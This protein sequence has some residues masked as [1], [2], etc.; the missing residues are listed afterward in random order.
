MYIWT[1]AGSLSVIYRI[2]IISCSSLGHLLFSKSAQGSVICPGLLVQIKRVFRKNCMYS[3]NATGSIL[4]ALCVSVVWLKT[5]NTSFC[6]VTCIIYCCLDFSWTDNLAKSAT[7]VS[8]F[9]F[10]PSLLLSYYFI[11]AFVAFLCTKTYCVDTHLKC[12][13]E[14]IPVCTLKIYKITCCR[15]TLEMP[16]MSTHNI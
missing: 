16:Q 12:F 15:Y 11:A 5:F 13:I 14:A 1:L 7:V 9:C 6:N 4:K 10:I 2:E 8:T 3:T